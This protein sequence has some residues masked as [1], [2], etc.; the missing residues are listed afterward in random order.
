[1]FGRVVRNFET[2]RVSGNAFLRL[3]ED[4][5]RELAPLIGERTNVR[6]LLKQSKQDTTSNEIEESSTDRSSA[7]RENIPLQDKTNTT[8]TPHSNK[9]PTNWHLSFQ[10]PQKHTF[11]GVVQKAV[12]TGVVC[13]KARRD[14]VQTLRTLILQHTRYLSLIHI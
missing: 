5:L 10:I 3:T 8:T 4:D 12:E 9:V 6:E 7:A 11:S 2:N 1:M 13:A 14:I